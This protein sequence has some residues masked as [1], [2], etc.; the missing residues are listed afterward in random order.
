MFDENSSLFDPK[1]G[2]I[3]GKGSIIN[4]MDKIFSKSNDNL[5]FQSE[6]V[7]VDKNNSCIE[8]LLT[9]SGN[10]PIRGVDMI[11]WQNGKISKIYAYMES[12][13]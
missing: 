8:F 2:L 5:N 10:D 3:E 4:F 6:V 11:T 12:N 1:V 9:L 13:E 7:L